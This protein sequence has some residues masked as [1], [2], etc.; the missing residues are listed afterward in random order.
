M[1]GD[2]VGF[3]H[4]QPIP[5]QNHLT[6]Y[7]S[8][9]ED[10]IIVL[11][12]SIWDVHPLLLSRAIC[13]MVM[14]VQTHQALLLWE[15]STGQNDIKIPF[16]IIIS[17]SRFFNYEKWSDEFL[18][19]NTECSLK[20]NRTVPGSTIVPYLHPKVYI[21]GGTVLPVPYGWWFMSH[22]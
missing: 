17:M 15:R 8:M 19:V 14:I 1:L 3:Y 21:Q 22:E 2:V 12:S 13:A 20:Q 11:C 18:W 5:E 16:I 7:F 4:H 9:Y 6:R 10:T